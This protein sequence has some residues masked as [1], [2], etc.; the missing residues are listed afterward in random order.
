MDLVE[1]I[2]RIEIARGRS[3]IIYKSKDQHGNDI[4]IKVISDGDFLTKTFNY[5]AIGAPTYYNWSEDAIN[6]ASYRRLVLEELVPYWTNSHVRIPKSRGVQWNKK[7]N[8]YE[9]ITE[10]IDGRHA[11]L[12][13]PFSQEKEHEIKEL[14]KIVMKHMQQMLIHSGFDGLVWQ[15]GLGIPAASANFMLENSEEGG[16][17]WVWVDLE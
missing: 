10:L 5:F 7:L 13:H 9:I 1:T 6:A 11:S 4:A 12:H 15:A 3:G 14:E 2:E 17:K 16:N 8:S